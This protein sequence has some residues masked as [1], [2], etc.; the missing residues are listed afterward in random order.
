VNEVSIIKQALFFLEEAGREK[1][2]NITQTGALGR[3]FVQALWDQFLK[4]SDKDLIFRPTREL[5]CPE[6]TLIYFL[7]SEGKFIRKVKGRVILTNKGKAALALND[8]SPLYFEL[9]QAGAYQWKWSYA[10][11][12]PE[13]PFIQQS[14]HM[15]IGSLCNAEADHVSPQQVYEDVLARSLGAVSDEVSEQIQRCLTVRFFYRFCVPFGILRAEEGDFFMDKK[16]ED[17][18]EKTDFCKNQFMQILINEPSIEDQINEKRRA[19]SKDQTYF[20]PQAKR[21]W[22]KVPGNIRLRLL[23]N[24]FCVSCK[25]ETGI[26]NPSGEMKR[27]DLLLTGVCTKCGTPVA[28]LVEGDWLNHR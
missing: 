13:F 19:R 28:R 9:Y 27:G 26:G 8:L 14:V 6:A 2:I 11:G 5:D 4:P 22:Q 7:L 16:S 20:T 17:M 3:N 1:G 10:D 12:Y 23:N 18:F 25:D 15:L 24:A 21:F